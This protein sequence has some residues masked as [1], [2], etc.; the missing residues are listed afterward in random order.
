MAGLVKRMIRAL[1]PSYSPP[2]PNYYETPFSE[3]MIGKDAIYDYWDNG[4]RTL[5]DK[6]SGYEVLAIQ[7]NL[8]IA[9]WQARF[10]HINSGK[11]IALDC[12]FLIEFDENL[13]CRLFRE[14]WHS[15]VIEA[16]Q[17]DNPVR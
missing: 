17:I 3:P 1:R 14:W 16:G 5:K 9:R 13:K 4:A 12:I 8:G 10:T 7:G 11:R 6:E 15:Q 2:M